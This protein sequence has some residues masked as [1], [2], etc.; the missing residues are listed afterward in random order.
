MS[1]LARATARA[2]V[3]GAVAALSLPAHA[4]GDRASW[5]HSLRQP[6]TGMSCCDIADCHATQA[7]WRQGG[8]WAKVDGEWEPVPGEKL[9]KKT[10]IDGQAYVCSGP[11][12]VIYCFVPPVLGM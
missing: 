7:D 11:E 9:L 8:W 2:A 10:S 12:H 6:A 3:L 4:E 1:R 5:F